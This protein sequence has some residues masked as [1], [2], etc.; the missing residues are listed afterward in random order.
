[1]IPTNLDK[2]EGLHINYYKGET[3]MNNIKSGIFLSVVFVLVFITSVFGESFVEYRSDKYLD[4]Y[5]YD[6]DS[7]KYVSK[8]IVEVKDVKLYGEESKKERLQSLRKWGEPIEKWENLGWEEMTIQ[9]NCKEKKRGKYIDNIF[10]YDKNGNKI[11][12]Y[13]YF[14]SNK[15]DWIRIIPGSREDFLRKEICITEQ[16]WVGVQVDDLGNL[17]SYKKNSLKWKTKNIVQFWDREDFSNEGREDFIKSYINEGIPT[18]GYEKLSHTKSLKEIDC[19]EGKLK[20]LSINYIG[21]DG[22][23]ISSITPKEPSWNYIIPESIGDELRNLV[24]NKP[25]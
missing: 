22:K 17:R 19:K 24:C 10:D 21:S 20:F 16:G 4:K 25:K 14:E 3:V 2:Q 12:H 11:P 1:M 6:K 8:D 7:L 5:F 18:E 15:S 13:V 23:V 9:I